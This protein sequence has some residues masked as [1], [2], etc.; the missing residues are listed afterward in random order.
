[1]ADQK[2]LAFVVANTA[3]VE[4]EAYAARMP[5]ILYPELVK[6]DTSANA[7]SQSVVSYN[8]A[9]AGLAAFTET[10]AGDFPTVD[11]KKEQ[12]IIAVKTAGIAYGYSLEEIGL[13]M[14]TGT[15]LSS[16]LAISARRAYEEFVDKTVLT[17]Q[18][19]DTGILNAASTPVHAAGS[20]VGKVGDDRFKALVALFSGMNAAT[21]NAV[22]PNTVLLPA[23]VLIEMSSER[24]P[25]LA[26]TYLDLLKAS[27]PY[28]VATGNALTVKGLSQLDALNKVIAYNKADDVVKVHI[29]MPLEFQAPYWQN[30][31]YVQIAGVFRLSGVNIIR[32]NEFISSAA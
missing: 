6:V 29:P 18:G 10:T 30:P 23:S 11:L 22:M 3:H 28:T 31:T 15:N 19:S 5:N 7:F 17:G 21:E 16:D 32:K 20:I 27:N 2:Q 4:S 1:M 8:T 12:S 14:M 26:M 13:A 24:V 9:Q 25:N